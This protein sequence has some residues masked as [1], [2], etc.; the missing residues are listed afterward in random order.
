MEVGQISYQIFYRMWSAWFYRH[1]N[2]LKL[3][4][5]LNG[6]ITNI[7]YILYPCTLLY[8]YGVEGMS[9]LMKSLVIVPAFGFVSLSLVRLKINRPR[10]YEVFQI[11]PLVP[12]SAKGRSMPSRHVFS[13][14][15]ISICLLNVSVHFGITC[16]MLSLVLACCRVLGGVHF[17]SDVL[18]STL[19]AGL[20]G[21][22]MTVL[23]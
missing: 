14:M 7:M 4:R 2:L 19:Y 16:L 23:Y 21:L 17:I 11:V 18:V 3:M 1:P 13:A 15:M 20:L 10:P 8:V 12:H 9:W 22:L 5:Q 6:T